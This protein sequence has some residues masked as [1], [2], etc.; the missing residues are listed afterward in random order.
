MGDWKKEMDD[1]EN[2]GNGRT[3]GRMGALGVA[4]TVTPPAASVGRHFLTAGA[5]FGFGRRRLS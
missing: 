5:P 4:P 3:D 2:K 1:E